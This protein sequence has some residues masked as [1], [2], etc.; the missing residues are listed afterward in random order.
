MDTLVIDMPS[1]TPQQDVNAL[2]TKPWATHGNIA[3]AHA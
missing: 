1:F 2:V 3:N